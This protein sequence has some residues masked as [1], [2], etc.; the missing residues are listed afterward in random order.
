MYVWHAS[1]C[2]KMSMLVASLRVCSPWPM[3]SLLSGELAVNLP[4]CFLIQNS[5]E[6]IPTYV[7]DLMRF[8]VCNRRKKR[9]VLPTWHDAWILYGGRDWRRHLRSVYNIDDDRELLR[10]SKVLKYR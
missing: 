7:E 6:L 5:N 1:Q 8:S 9:E 4:T 2:G 3:A 10:S